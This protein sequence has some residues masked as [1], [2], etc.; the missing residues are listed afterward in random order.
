MPIL[1][2][3]LL[4]ILVLLAAPHG[5][6]AVGLESVKFIGPVTVQG[7][8][9]RLIRA[10]FGFA[11]M[12]ALLMFIYGGFTIMTAQGSDEKIKKGKSMITNAVLGL[13]AMFLAYSITG[14]IIGA[15]AA[16]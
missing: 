4:L 14:F 2:P 7:L 5:V 15:L 13:I 6:D 9:G 16:A 3:I 11:G 1:S 10:L 12:I 8:V